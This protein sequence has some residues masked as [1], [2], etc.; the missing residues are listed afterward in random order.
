MRRPDFL[1]LL[2]LPVALATLAACG[3]DDAAAMTGLEEARALLEQDV[4]QDGHGP[5]RH[6]VRLQNELDLTDA[7]V[8]ELRSILQ[9][10][11]D[12]FQALHDGTRDEVMARHEALREIWPEMHGAMLSVL[13]EE[14]RARLEGLRRS[15]GS[16]DGHMGSHGPRGDGHP[17]S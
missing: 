14:Q 12:E 4:D 17:G 3:N 8:A 11:R 13:T 7:Q 16:P 2:V 10:Q 15:H 1:A 9:E 5:E 6:L